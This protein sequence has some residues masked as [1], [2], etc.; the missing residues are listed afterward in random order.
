MS[1]AKDKPRKP[2]GCPPFG[3]KPAKID[4]GKAS[5]KYTVRRVH[6]ENHPLN[7]WYVLEEI[8]SGEIVCFA[9]RASHVGFAISGQSI[10]MAMEFAKHLFESS[11]DEM[12]LDFMTM[13]VIR[14]M[15]AGCG[16]EGLRRIAEGMSCKTIKAKRINEDDDAKTGIDEISEALD[17]EQMA[18]ELRRRS[19]GLP[20]RG[21]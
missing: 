17:I 16:H 10:T 20:P 13:G 15:L 12:V 7:G 4:I 18:N 5:E 11:G 9:P 6:D 8:D 2:K 19:D 21:D 1:D 3:S 14:K